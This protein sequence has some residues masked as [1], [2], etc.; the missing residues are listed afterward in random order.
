MSGPERLWCDACQNMATVDCLCG[1]DLCVCLNYGERDCPKCGG[2]SAYED[3]DDESR[4]ALRG[5]MGEVST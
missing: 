5:V 1:G 3:D 2:V 4:D